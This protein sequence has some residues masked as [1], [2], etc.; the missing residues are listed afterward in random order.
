MSSSEHPFGS[1]KMRGSAPYVQTLTRGILDR[2]ARIG[3]I[4]L[5]LGGRRPDPTL[6]IREDSADS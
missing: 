3:D 1:G 2:N 4:H 6:V 5:T